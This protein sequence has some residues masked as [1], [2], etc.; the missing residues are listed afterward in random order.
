MQD[1]QKSTNLRVTSFLSQ[2]QGLFQWVS[3]SYQVVKVL[4]VGGTE[5]RRRREQQRMRWLNGITNSMDMNFSKLSEL[6]MDREAWCA[7]VHG[8]TKSD[9]I[10]WLNWT[11]GWHYG[12]LGRRTIGGNNIYKHI[13]EIGHMENFFKIMFS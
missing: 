13:M 11:E 5:G 3:S 6:V 7:A 4:E 10:E 12:N 8:V 2:H 9:T 1:I